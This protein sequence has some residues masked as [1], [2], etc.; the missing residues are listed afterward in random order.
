MFPEN[1]VQATF[2]QVQTHYV[3]VKQRTVV[4]GSL[5]DTILNGT[6]INENTTNLIPSKTNTKTVLKQT[7]I[8]TNEVNVLGI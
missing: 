2:Q 5:N 1:I 6:I 7:L 4:R 8:Y 3:P